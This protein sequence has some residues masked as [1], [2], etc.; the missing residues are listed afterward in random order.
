[1]KN[2]IC[3]FLLACSILLC[4]CSHPERIQENMA[5]DKKQLEMI[6][7]MD[8]S[9]TEDTL[10]L[11]Y[12]VSNP[13]DGDIRVCHAAWVYGNREV[14]HAITRIRDK[15]VRIILGNVVKDRNVRE[16]R[17]TQNPRPIAKYVRLAPGES[18][19]GRVVLDLPIRDYSVEPAPRSK[20]PR[21]ENT[22]ITLRRVVFEVGYF[23]PK[24]NKFFS[25]VSDRD[26]MDAVDPKPTIIGP[27][28][29]LSH[30]PA[31]IEE[32]VDGKLRE[33]VYV[34]GRSWDLE[35]AKVVLMADAAVP[36]SVPEDK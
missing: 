26:K 17:V 6:E 31:I 13:F 18:Y 8:I 12:K 33:V 20:R 11:D 15:T 19:S 36:C 25:T 7:I 14:Q 3:K 23:G 9:V 29:Y 28:Y 24:W 22:D 2:V 34:R 1:M 4:G 35:S 21:E 10:T 27:Y 5:Y 32:T 16:L 30:N